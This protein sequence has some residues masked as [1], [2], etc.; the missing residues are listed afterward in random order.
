VLEELR[1][2]TARSGLDV[3]LIDVWE[4]ADA[5]IE[6]QRYRD[7]W[8]IGGT[9]LM[10]ESATYAREL[11]VRGVPTNVIVDDE[12]IVR[13]VGGTSA[14]EL[15]AALAPLHPEAAALLDSHVVERVSAQQGKR[16]GP[17]VGP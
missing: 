17:L 3:I 7:M 5:P 9:V 8:G 2:R 15:Q 11:G 10:D 12:G 13:A 1:R 4:G 16:H 14:A 6:A